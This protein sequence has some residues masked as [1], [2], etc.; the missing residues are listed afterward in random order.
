[1]NEI[2]QLL[3]QNE[4]LVLAWRAVVWA[5]AVYLFVLGAIT[6]IRPSLANRFLGGFAS[7]RLMNSVEAVLRLIVGLAFMATSPAM[8]LSV[9]F[10]W[11]GAILALTAIAIMFL[12]DLHRSFR[13]SVL[14][15]LERFL[16][17]YGALS[18]ALGAVIAWALNP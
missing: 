7:S 5:C 3:T 12:Y 1:M 14:P 18:I 2:V 17:V 4:F 15:L 10:F 6:F 16:P 13:P 11:S 9:V 8:K